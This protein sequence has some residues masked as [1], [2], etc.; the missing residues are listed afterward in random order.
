MWIDLAP[1]NNTKDANETELCGG[2]VGGDDTFTCDFVV[3]AS[4]FIAGQ[5][6]TIS[7][8]DG[9]AQK[10]DIT[11]TWVL[12]GKVTAVPDSAAIGDTVTIEFRDFPD[13][14]T[15]SRFDLGGVDISGQLTLRFHAGEQQQLPHNHSG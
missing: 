2:A 11:A 10:A 5:S 13:G 15:V 9:R 8:V 14:Q 1:L 4:N 7:A 3:N 6:A 12:K